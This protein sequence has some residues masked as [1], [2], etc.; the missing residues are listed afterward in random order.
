MVGFKRKKSSESSDVCLVRERER[1]RERE[2][3]TIKKI[4]RHEAI[5][6]YTGINLSRSKNSLLD[7][8]SP[9]TEPQPHRKANRPT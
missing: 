6:M 9:Q 4:V 8:Q 5:N 2:R 3:V 7:K 1:E